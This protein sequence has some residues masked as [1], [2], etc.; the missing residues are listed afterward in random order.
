M[1][2]SAGICRRTDRM[3][4][5]WLNTSSVSCFWPGFNWSSVISSRL[6]GP[7]NSSLNVEQCTPKILPTSVCKRPCRTK[8]LALTGTEVVNQCYTSIL[9]FFI[10]KITII[11]KQKC[12]PPLKAHQNDDIDQNNV[13]YMIRQEKE[14]T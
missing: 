7:P 12:S 13:V 11:T 10:V 4:T 3:K 9:T 8:I 6:G 5:K 14:N 2:I 1:Q